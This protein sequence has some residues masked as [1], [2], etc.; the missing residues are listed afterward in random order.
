[1]TGRCGNALKDAAAILYRIKLAQQMDANAFAFL[2]MDDAELLMRLVSKNTRVSRCLG[3]YERREFS[4]AGD[5]L[6]ELIMEIAHDRNV[7]LAGL[8]NDRPC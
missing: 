3:A 4:E 5:M 1:M 2:S 7:H 6:R 8:E